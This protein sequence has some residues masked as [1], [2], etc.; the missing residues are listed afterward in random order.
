MEIN[1]VVISGSSP[2]IIA[3]S[4]TD[5]IVVVGTTTETISR[6]FLIPANTFKISGQ[7]E[8]FVRM[9]KTGNLGTST[10]KMYKNTSNALAGSTLIGVFASNLAGTSTYVQ[11]GR[12]ARI[13]S[14][15]LS[16]FPTNAIFA[17]DY[18]YNANPLTSTTFTTSVDNYIIFS[19]QL[20]STSDS[21][22]VSMSRL[23]KYE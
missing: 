11:G 1:G 20:G 16:I 7:L 17:F 8:I 9:T 12:T 15:T 10:L 19:I 5:G 4:S 13:V 18:T 23:I 3:S 6:S 2:T 22:N 14:N 21:A